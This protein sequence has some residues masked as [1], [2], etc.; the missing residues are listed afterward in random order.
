MCR[1]RNSFRFVFFLALLLA[2]LNSMNSKTFAQDTSYEPLDY[3]GT[4]IEVTGKRLSKSSHARLADFTR[5]GIRLSETYTYLPAGKILLLTRLCEKSRSRIWCFAVTQ[6]GI[7]IYV[8]VRGSNY[9]TIA[10]TSGVM[11]I[12]FNEVAVTL[13]DGRNCSPSAPTELNRLIA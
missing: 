7:P 11:T 5:F 13:P 3:L 1:T 8:G 2:S 4:N 12:V 10:P 6:N 9:F